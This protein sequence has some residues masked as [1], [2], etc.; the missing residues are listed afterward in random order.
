MN[1]ESWCDEHD[2]DYSE[3]EVDKSEFC[4]WGDSNWVESGRIWVAQSRS[5]IQVMTNPQ[6][7]AWHWDVEAPMDEF[8]DPSEGLVHTADGIRFYNTGQTGIVIGSSGDD[9]ETLLEMND[10]V[11]DLDF[12]QGYR[13][14]G[15]D[16]DDH[17]PMGGADPIP[18]D[19]PDELEKRDDRWVCP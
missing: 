5:G 13:V 17:L 14:D 15:S 7:A 2:A 18:W 19:C 8:E 3:Q 10:A 11:A 9:V 12:E 16:F 1:L 4:E 6:E